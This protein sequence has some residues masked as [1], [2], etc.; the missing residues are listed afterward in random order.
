MNS[1]DLSKAEENILI[2]IATIKTTLQGKLRTL[3]E[4]DE[5]LLLKCEFSEIE[6]II[7]EL[8]DVTAGVTEI[9]NKIDSFVKKA[10]KT[11]LSNNS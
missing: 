8:T 4:I 5:K 11:K 10:E 6:K 3:E 2:K 1:E 9:L 7:E